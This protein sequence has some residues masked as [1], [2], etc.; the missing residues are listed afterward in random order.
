[1]SIYSIVGLTRSSGGGW[2]EAKG[3][4]VAGLTLQQILQQGY[5][6]FERCHPL[7][8]YVRKAA[9]ALLVCRTAVL[10]GHIQACPEGQVERVWY[11]SCR[12]RLC[13]QC[14]WLQVERWLV[15]QKAR[16]LACEHYHVIF[17]WPD[18]L[19]GLWRANVRAMTNLLCATV[20]ETLAELLG[21]AKYLGACPGRIAALHT[22]S[23]TLVWHP[24][25][26]GLVTGGGLTDAGQ[27]R[28]VRNGFL[29]PGRVVLALLRGTRLAAI[30]TAI[31]AGQLSLPTRLTLRQWETRRH[32]LGRRKWQVHIRERYPHG[33]GV[34]TYRAR[35][36]RGG[37]LAKQR[38]VSSHRG[39][40]TFRYRVNGEASD[41]QAQG[42]LTLPLAEFIR[43][44]LLHV[45][46]PG[47]KVVRCYGLYAPTKQEAVAVC[48]A[49]W[50]QAPVVQ[51]PRLTWQEYCQD[52]GD[53]HPERCPVWGRRLVCLDLLLQSRIPPPGQVPWEVVA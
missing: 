32:K 7:P 26:H 50:G 9:W 6:A 40:V 38:L 36:I 51:P 34:L 12:H 3:A 20:H 23:Q 13:P 5:A 47:T 22:W 43:R 10:G 35:D 30:D 18:E 33:T 1:M 2:C 24:H 21:D 31:R 41:R 14:A 11:N 19:R 37:P 8:A 48:R 28:P 52:R 46:E 29:R 39:E 44:Y 42:L 16:L 27:W 53:A 25:R 17:T 49:Q 4:V 45:P 15:Q